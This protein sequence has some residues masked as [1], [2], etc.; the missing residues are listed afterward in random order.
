[1][2]QKH[3]PLKYATEDVNALRMSVTFNH[4]L[5][6]FLCVYIYAFGIQSDFT[7]IKYQTRD[8]WVAI[9]RL[10]QLICRNTIW[11][12]VAFAYLHSACFRPK[13]LKRQWQ[14]HTLSRVVSYVIVFR[15]ACKG[16]VTITLAWWK[17][18]HFDLGLIGI[19]HSK[20]H[21]LSSFIHPYVI[22]NL[23]EDI[24][25]NVHTMKVD[26]GPT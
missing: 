22:R 8:L 18:Q 23:H 11:V 17:K 6:Y 1:M 9:A 2:R 26:G 14:L 19:V 5:L 21:I 13:L 20:I 3:T 16:P 24:C 15:C 10:Y 4:I 12:Y 25:R 7:R